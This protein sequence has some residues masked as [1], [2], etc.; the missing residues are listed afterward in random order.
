[1]NEV[2]SGERQQQAWT[3]KERNN[4]HT[5]HTDCLA[6]ESEWATPVLGLSG[7]GIFHIPIHVISNWPISFEIVSRRR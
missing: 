5:E 1:M 4:Q 7:A 6:K 3:K 2:Y